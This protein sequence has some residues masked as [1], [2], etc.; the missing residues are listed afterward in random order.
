MNFTELVLYSGEETG[1]HR[2]AVMITRSFYPACTK[3][4]HPQKIGKWQT[5]E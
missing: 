2:T 4:V 3:N 1:M 5:L